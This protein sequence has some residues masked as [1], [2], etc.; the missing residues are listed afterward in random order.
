LDL[1]EGHEVPEA[2]GGEGDE[3]V[4]DGVEVGPACRQQQNFNYI[5]PGAGVEPSIIGL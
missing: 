3:A 1:L 4:V 2:D 5:S